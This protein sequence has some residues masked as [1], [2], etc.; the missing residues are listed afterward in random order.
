[1]DESTITIRT[2]MLSEYPRLA[3]VLSETL[4]F[5]QEAVP[6]VF[7]VTDRPPPSREFVAGLLEDG[8]GA[9]FIAEDDE[10]LVGFLTVRVGDSR[11]IPYLVPGRRAVVD[12]LGILSAWRGLG[13]GHRLMEA[14]ESWAVRKRA[15][16]LQLNVWEFNQGAI[17]FYESQ[18]Y[19]TFSRNM[20]KELSDST[21]D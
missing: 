11:E 14:A 5:H 10:Q 21:A 13:L 8:S 4:A 12:N 19:T 17:G 3:A 9:L 1:M 2:A 20:W 18:G 16:Q 6:Q 7:R 15:T